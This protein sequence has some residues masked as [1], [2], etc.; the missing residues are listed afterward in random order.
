MHT[1]FSEISN[2]IRNRRTTK[3]G[4]M[5]GQRIPDEQVEKLLEL[6]DWAPTHGHTEPWRFKVYAGDKVQDFC[7]AHAELYRKHTEQEKYLQEK[8][9]KLLYMGDK[10]SHV[11]VAYMQRGNLPKIPALEEIAATSCAIQNLLLGATALGIASYWGSGGMAYRPPMKELLQ[12]REEDVVLGILYLGYS[13]TP[14]TVGK[15]IVPLE[16]KVVWM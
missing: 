9:D 6:A 16:E 12:L 1:S 3:P 4:K 11:I 10:V 15:R 13:D 5:N 2:I 8:Y 14:A 7:Q